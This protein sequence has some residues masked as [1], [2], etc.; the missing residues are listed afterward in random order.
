MSVPLR[1]TEEASLKMKVGWGE[2]QRMTVVAAVTVTVAT[3]VTVGGNMTVDSIVI[4]D[5]GITVGELVFT[6]VVE[7]WI[8]R[9]EQADEIS[10]EGNA[11][12]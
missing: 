9:H 5:A 4:V 12:T 7:G 1:M 10:E 11:E 8:E 6:I 2:S 3:V